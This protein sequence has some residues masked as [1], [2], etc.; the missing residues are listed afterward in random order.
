[1]MINCCPEFQ[2]REARSTVHEY[3]CELPGSVV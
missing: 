2:I 1:M 3:P